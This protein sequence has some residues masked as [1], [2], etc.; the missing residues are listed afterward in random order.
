MEW[1]IRR[2]KRDGQL[3]SMI[4]MEINSRCNLRCIYCPVSIN[5]PIHLP[6]LMSRT[7][8][9]RLLSELERLE[10][11]GRV[12][13]HFYNEPLLHPDLDT[14][15]AEVKSRLPGARHVLYTNSERLDEKK[16]W[17]LRT[18][19]VGLFVVTSH[20]R[21]LIPPRDAQVVLEPDDLKLTNRGGALGAAPEPLRV[22]CHLPSTLLVVTVTGDVLLCYEDYYRTQ[23]MGNVM[24][25]PLDEIWYSP[26]FVSLRRSLAEGKR[27]DTPICRSCNNT[28][29]T[30]PIHY[31][32]VP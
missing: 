10:F 24:E 29:H 26:R 18:A 6:Q 7:V 31:D 32:Y 28:A 23:V 16:Y 5:A 25:K 22:L 30:T 11:S 14:V 13:Y 19:G 15:I 17:Q 9:D 27:A 21:R 1:S 12:S 3:F 8:L 20:R 2:L 4:E